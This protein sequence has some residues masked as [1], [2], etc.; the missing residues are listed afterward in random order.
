[1]RLLKLG[2]LLVALGLILTFS[3]GFVLD[4]PEPV[5]GP[6]DVV[7]VISGDDQ[8]ARFREG[9][10]LYERGLA[11]Y[12]VFSGAARDGSL[13]NG[14]VMRQMAMDAG[15]PDSAI[16]VEPEGQDTWGNAVGTRP[17]VE[18]IGAKEVILVTS[19]YHVRRANLTFERAFQGSNIR[20]V[21]HSAPDSEWRKL[22]W[23]G[24]SETR[25]LTISELEKLA[26]IAV[27]GR[28][29]LD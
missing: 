17:L 25:R 5:L 28:Y 9:L 2:A 13:S 14:S 10:R 3:A 8:H 15:I 23:W 18:K 1:V 11:R 16:L 4:A 29:R 6:A 7:V 21:A 27:T 24:N 12:I 26:Y 22:S 20:V 19:P